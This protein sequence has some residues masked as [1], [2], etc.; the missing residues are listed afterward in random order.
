MRYRRTRR[1]ANHA[2]IVDALERVGCSVLDL[3]AVGGGCPDLLVGIGGRSF[4]VEVKNSARKGGKNNNADTL[5]KQREFREA[6][7]GRT[8][9]VDSVDAAL[10]EVCEC[11]A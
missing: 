9:V 3:A 2:D 6:W 7:K 11:A 10:R 4:L 8:A 5:T 1:D